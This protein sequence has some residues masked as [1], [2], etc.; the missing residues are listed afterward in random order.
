MQR[1]ESQKKNKGLIKVL[2]PMWGLICK[3]MTITQVD[4]WMELDF[5]NIKNATDVS[6]REGDFL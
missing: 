2:F 5:K 3:R 1:M 4:G 6:A